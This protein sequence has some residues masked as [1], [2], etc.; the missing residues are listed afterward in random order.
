MKRDELIKA[1]SN[2]LIRTQNKR[3]QELFYKRKENGDI[4]IDRVTKE[5][6]NSFSQRML[7]KFKKYIEDE[8]M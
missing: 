5:D 7:E 3:L 1:C 6:F 4:V 8:Q 2:I